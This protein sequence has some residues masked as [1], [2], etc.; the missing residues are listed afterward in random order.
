MICPLMS[1]P[2]G[3]VACKEVTC[4][5]WIRTRE[6]SFEVPMDDNGGKCGLKLF[7]L[8]TLTKNN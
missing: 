8:Q 3:M 1:S 6:Y 7:A 4:A 5:L 2:E